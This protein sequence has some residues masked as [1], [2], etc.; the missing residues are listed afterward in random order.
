MN[1][2]VPGYPIRLSEYFFSQAP[3]GVAPGTGA[4]Y[5]LGRQL[6]A[7]NPNGTPVAGFPKN[8][9]VPAAGRFF[10]NQAE[11]PNLVVGVTGNLYYGGMVDG[12]P[13]SFGSYDVF[14]QSLNGDGAQ[15]SGFPV[16]VGTSEADYSV[17]VAIDL[18]SGNLWVLWYSQGAAT[19]VAYVTRF[20]AN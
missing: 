12:Q 6:Y 4:V 16:F 2:T 17:G 8:P 20:N 14:G 10:F 18:S 19:R 15:R 5:V 11:T 13:G 9:P 3:L 7:Y 1:N